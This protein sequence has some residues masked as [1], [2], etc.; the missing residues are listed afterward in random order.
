MSVLKNDAFHRM[1]LCT[2]C[3]RIVALHPP[4]PSTAALDINGDHTQLDETCWSTPYSLCNVSWDRKP[5]GKKNNVATNPVIPVSAG[6]LVRLAI[7]GWNAHLHLSR[8]SFFIEPRVSLG[9][10]VYSTS[11]P[12]PPYIERAFSMYRDKKLAM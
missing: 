9:C 12:R 7:E 11:F 2:H 6:H 8:W 10:F 3:Q 4:N 5:R 1:I